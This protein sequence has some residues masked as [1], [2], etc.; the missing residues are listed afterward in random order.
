[1]H[2]ILFAFELFCVPAYFCHLLFCPGYYSCLFYGGFLFI[3]V[4]FIL[5]VLVFASAYEIYYNVTLVF[6]VNYNGFVLK[7]KSHCMHNDICIT[8]VDLF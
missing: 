8:L 4:R 1:M 7:S 3:V 2:Y 5:F 6:N